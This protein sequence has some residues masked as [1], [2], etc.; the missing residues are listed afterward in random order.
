MMYDSGKGVGDARVGQGLGGRG[1]RCANLRLDFLLDDGMYALM[2]IGKWEDVRAR[3]V[4]R[5]D[6]RQ[7]STIVYQM[8]KLGMGG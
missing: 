7:I 3:I 4:D 5:R 2:L 8:E 1:K 6:A